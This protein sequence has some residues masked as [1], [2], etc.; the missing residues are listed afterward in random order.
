[1]LSSSSGKI[2]LL[3]MVGAL[4][5]GIAFLGMAIGGLWIWSKS[6]R[7]TKQTGG[8]EWSKPELPSNAELS[9][10]FPRERIHEIHGGIKSTPELPAS[11]RY[12]LTGDDGA[13]EMPTLD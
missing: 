7:T 11:G 12:E 10:P 5:G 1:M 13:R 3:T 8:P 2:S 6:R 9:S 4:L